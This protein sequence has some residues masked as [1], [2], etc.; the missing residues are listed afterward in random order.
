[1][2]KVFLDTNLLLDFLLDRKPF[3]RDVAVI[4]NHS[5]NSDLDIDVAS[6]SLLNVNYIIAKAE[7]KKSAHLKTSKIN[8]LVNVLSVGQK[9]MNQ[10]LLSKFKDFEDGVQNFCASNNNHSIIITR[11]VKDYKESELSILTPE[12]YLALIST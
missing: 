6:I 12:E 5:S 1:M 2:N 4:L 11:N 8:S 10:S 9:E 7:N 3:S